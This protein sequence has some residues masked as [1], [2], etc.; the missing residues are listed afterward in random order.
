VRSI[1]CVHARVFLRHHCRWRPARL[2]RSD[3]RLHRIPVA[4][5]RGGFRSPAARFDPDP[6]AYGASRGCP[7]TVPAQ[8]ATLTD[9]A[10]SFV[11]HCCGLALFVSGSTTRAES[12]VTAARRNMSQRKLRVG[13]ISDTHGVLRPQALEYLRGSDF[14]VHAGDIG[15]GSILDALE[16][17][18]AVTAVRGNNDNGPWAAA[19]PESNAL[20]AADVRIYVVHDLKCIDF[21]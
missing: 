10:I 13:L 11:C 21:D 14:I 6:G 8:A 9:A 2:R 16:K 12:R 19:L 3:P 7:L 18:A 5:R 15:N 1:Q 17:L 20:R 4:D